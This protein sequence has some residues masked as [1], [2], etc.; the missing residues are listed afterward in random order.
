M[1][2]NDGEHP[3]TSL[4]GVPLPDGSGAPGTTGIA[5]ATT[6]GPVIGTPHVT[7][8]YGQYRD[9]P[10]VTVHTGDTSGMADDLAAHADALTP[11][12]QPDYADTG[13]GH[14]DGTSRTARYP[15]QQPNGGAKQ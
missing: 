14:G 12:P 7:P 4:F 3:V 10:D 11:G 8:A 6:T 13:A 2:S 9:G 5:A 15:W 1:A